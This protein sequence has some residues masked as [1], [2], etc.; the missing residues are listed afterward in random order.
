MNGTV[1]TITLMHWLCSGLQ[2]L[3]NRFQLFIDVQ[4][5]LA[6]NQRRDCAGWSIRH[7]RYGVKSHCY[8]LLNL[9]YVH[10]VLFS[11]YCSIFSISS[12][13]SKQ[14]KTGMVRLSLCKCFLKHCI[15]FIYMPTRI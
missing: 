9:F 14:D 6:L 1:L 4:E 5:Q 11:S 12:S 10:D 15:I 3:F 8:E 7:I 2:L 13:S